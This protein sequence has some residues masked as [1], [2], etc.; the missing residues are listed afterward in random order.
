LAFLRKKVTRISGATEPMKKVRER[1]KLVKRTEGHKRNGGGLKRSN[2]IGT[3]TYCQ[4]VG[5]GGR[6]ALQTAGKGETFHVVSHE[7]KR[8]R[9]EKKWPSPRKRLVQN[10]DFGVVSRRGDEEE[11]NGGLLRVPNCGLV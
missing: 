9:K 1:K 2:R 11:A 6:W 7:S 8:D 5:M 4:T 10:E 3:T